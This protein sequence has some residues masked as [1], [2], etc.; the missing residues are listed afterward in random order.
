METQLAKKEK[1]KEANNEE[2]DMKNEEIMEEKK[3]NFEA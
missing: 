3:L 2:Q 1:V